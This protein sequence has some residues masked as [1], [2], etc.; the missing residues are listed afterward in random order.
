MRISL[1]RNPPPTIDRV[2]IS[3]HESSRR[4]LRQFLMS[5]LHQTGIG[6]SEFIV[7]AIDLWR[8][9]NPEIQ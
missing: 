6:Y 3:V 9:V 7:M 1:R 4:K 8:R 5:D 2:A